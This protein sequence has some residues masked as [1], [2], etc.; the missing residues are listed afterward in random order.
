MSKD[1]LL[2]VNIDHVATIRE[3]RGV[4]YPSPADAALLAIESGADNITLHLREDRR[5]I[6]ER[7]VTLIQQIINVPLNFEM[8][9][10]DEIIDFAIE[11]KPEMCCIVPEK[12][13]ELTTEGGL[14]VVGLEAKVKSATKKLVNAGIS[15]SL[16]I[17]PDKDQ[18]DAAKRTG[19]DAVEIHTGRYAD[20]ET[21]DETLVEFDKI[22][23]AVEYAHEVG[24]RV[25]AGHGLHYY[26]VEP[27]A[28][29]EHLHTLNIGHS[30][31]AKAV[32]VGFKNA[33]SEMK[34]LIRNA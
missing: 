23:D 26:N 28:Q 2:G 3:A 21:E 14:D 29:L 24:L 25:D 12:R 18:I 34:K 30:I 1:I 7:D 27:I 10:S 6:K 20:A 19:A 15:V 31:V 33:V 22:A 5:H 17:E 32:M 13:E 16:F 4:R 8:A 9:L 11:I